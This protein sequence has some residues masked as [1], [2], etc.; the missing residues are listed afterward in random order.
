MNVIVANEKQNELANLDVDIIKNMTGVF[1]VNEIIE[2]FKSFFY[3]RMILD[4]TALKD[5]K[6]IQTYEVLSKELGADKIIFLLPEGSN[7]CTPNF[8]SHMIDLGIYNFT[9]NINGVKYLLNKPNTLKEVEHIKKMTNNIIPDDNKDNNSG[10][11]SNEVV[12]NNEST[13]DNNVNTSDEENNVPNNLTTVTTKV[14][15]GVTIVGFK[16]V[17]EHAGV[18]TLIYMLKKELSHVYGNDGVV[19]IELNKNDFSLFNDKNMVSAKENNIKS[20]I[21]NYPN[22][23]IVLVDLNNS[24]DNSYCSDVIYLLE[25]STIKLNKLIQKN[26]IIFSNLV[27]KKIVLNNSLLLNND[28]A[29]FENE[30]KIRVFYNLPPLD[31]RKRN[32]II[33]DFLMKL[34]LINNNSNSNSSGI[35]GLF[36]R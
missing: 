1:D 10:N 28:V 21:N 7:L 36:R 14:N 16:N 29:D 4:V 9:T 26:R 31:E 12:N 17:T 20:V 22:A 5:Y 11:D 2:T 3:S 13:F 6:E 30:A 25:P 33:K 23:Q 34:G 27:N 35:F 8:L 19:A 18:I 32:E 15:D 24:V